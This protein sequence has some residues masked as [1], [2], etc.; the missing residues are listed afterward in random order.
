MHLFAIITLILSISDALARQDASSATAPALSEPAD[1]AS[2]DDP[3][4]PAA[5]SPQAQSPAQSTVPTSKQQPKRILGVMPNYRA[6]SAGA[7]PPPATPK[8]AFKIA[9]QNSFDYSA[10]IFV[11][12]TSL[13]GGGDG[14]T[15]AAGARHRAAMADTTGAASR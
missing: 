3:Q 12:I 8:Q 6:V 1:S 9:T 14:R 4:N 5:T 15:H 7:I 11:G 13:A 10:F 2:S